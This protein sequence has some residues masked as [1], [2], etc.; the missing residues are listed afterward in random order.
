M[1]F[2]TNGKNDILEIQPEKVF[3]DFFGSDAYTVFFDENS[4][5][6]NEL[7]KA[8]SDRLNIF[9]FNVPYTLSMPGTVTDAGTG[10]CK[11]GIVYYPLT[12][13]M[14]QVMPYNLHYY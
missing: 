8:F 3:K 5:C 10:I 1:K 9:W 13:L 4:Y 14:K 7:Q 12:L 2:A 6:G 11:D